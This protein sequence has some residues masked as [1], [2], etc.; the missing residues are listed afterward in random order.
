MSSA[1][2]KLQDEINHR[3]LA[4]AY[5]VLALARDAASNYIREKPAHADLH[6]LLTMLEMT[7]DLLEGILDHPLPCETEISSERESAIYS[8]LI[9]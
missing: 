2:T 3:K 8:D 5:V 6:P 4:R 1:E 9:M 7:H